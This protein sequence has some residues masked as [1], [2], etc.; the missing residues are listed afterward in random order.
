MTVDLTISDAEIDAFLAYHNVGA[1]ASQRLELD[2]PRREL[3]KG[4]RDVRACPGSGKTTILAVKLL[5]LAGKWSAPHQGI[6]VL[7][8]TNVACDEIRDRLVGHPA[9]H[10]FETYPHFVGTIQE[11][12]HRF[13]ALPYIRSRAIKV[14]RIDDA[15][16]IGYMVRRA[17]QVVRTFLEK[18]NLSIAGLKLN[19]ETGLPQV[20]G[21]NAESDTPAYTAMKSLLMDRLK[22]GIFFYGEMYHYARKCIVEDPDVV[23]ALRLRFPAVFADEMQD[24]SDYQDDLIRSLFACDEVRLQRVGDPDQAIYGSMGEGKPNTSFNDAEDHHV[25]GTTHR[26]CNSVSEK[27]CGI[28][29]GRIGEIVSLAPAERVNYPHT[30]LLFDEGSKPHVLEAF[31][32]VLAD[33]D[34][35]FTWRSVKAVGANDGEGGFIQQYWPAFDKRKTPSSFRPLTLREAVLRN[36]NDQSPHA[37]QRY[38]AILR[39]VTDLLRLAGVRRANPGP[40]HSETTLIAMLKA[41]GSYVRFRQL[42]RQWIDQPVTDEPEW[43]LSIAALAEVLEIAVNEDPVQPFL[44]YALPDGDASPAEP[45]KINCFVASDGREIVVGTIHSVKGETHDA[46]LVLETQF[47]EWDIQQSLNHLAGITKEAIKGKR[48]ARAARLLYVGMS[49]PRH[50]VCLAMNREHISDAQIAAMEGIGWRIR[51]VPAPVLVGEA[52]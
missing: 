26:F 10:R 15:A 22:D 49:R 16:A 19:Y 47:H 8:H 35:Q 2:E 33:E 50:L 4:W 23:P 3:L 32:A 31:S 13:L 42:V 5:L 21:F 20:P 18:R 52:V 51:D 1:Q 43:R 25:I 39:A 12:V 30:V 44:D 27:I 41:K 24:T 17:N 36:W 46:T 14:H 38:A 29:V 37:Q 34:P 40:F 45:T 7:T 28:S 11:F 48:A 9:G 6:C